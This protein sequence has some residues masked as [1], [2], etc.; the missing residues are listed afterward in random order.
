MKKCIFC[1]ILTSLLSMCLM[2]CKHQPEEQPVIETPK[3][4]EEGVL[5]VGC[6]IGYAPMEYYEEDGVT[7]TG[8][9]MDLARM[10]AEKL[11]L[12]L[13]IVPCAWDAIFNNVENKAFDMIISS[14]SYTKERDEIHALSKSYLDNQLVIVVKNDSMLHEIADLQGK[15]IGVQ[16]ETTAD[17]FIRGYKEK[18]LNIELSQY[19][20]VINAFDA[21][22][23]GDVDAICADSVVANF[24]LIDKKDY[25]I[26][27]KSEAV[28]PLCICLAKDNTALRDEVNSILDELKENGDLKFLSRK[29]FGFEQ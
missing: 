28:E 14:V 7:C 29:Y 21:L 6:Q 27:W 24:Y 20:K 12:E 4:I 16:L 3:T 11:H 15:N 1:I 22:E 17:Y 23:R 25:K 19:E 18:D 5:K 2:G 26:A 9:D 8:Y 13:E 10:I